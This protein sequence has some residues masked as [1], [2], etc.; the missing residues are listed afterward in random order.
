MILETVNNTQCYLTL[1]PSVSID[2]RP[3][4]TGEGGQSI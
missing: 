4:S 1:P 2:P 3:Y